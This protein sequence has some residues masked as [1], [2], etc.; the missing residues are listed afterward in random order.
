MGHL[1]RAFDLTRRTVNEFRAC[2]SGTFAETHPGGG[3][4]VDIEGT[5]N[6]PQQGPPVRT[7]RE[8]GRRR[9]PRRPL[10]RADGIP[11]LLARVAVAAVTTVVWRG[12]EREVGGDALLGHADPVADEVR[13]EVAAAGDA[14]HEVRD[15]VVL[16]P[17]VRPPGAVGSGVACRIVRQDGR[18]V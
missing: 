5:F 15:V 3:P 8:R 2:F 14:D 7:R 17:A 1:P 13:D 4:S 18:A 11:W 6:V 9:R 12:E 10:R 16:P